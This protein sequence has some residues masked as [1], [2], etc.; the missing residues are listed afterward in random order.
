VALAASPDWVYRVVRRQLLLV[1]VPA[2][3]IGAVIG[4]VATIAMGSGNTIFPPLDWFLLSLPICLAVAGG[5][6]AVGATVTA[7]AARPAIR[8]S[9]TPDNLRTA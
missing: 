4:W 8:E 1:A 6:A 5:A 7:G 2:A 9:S 3:V